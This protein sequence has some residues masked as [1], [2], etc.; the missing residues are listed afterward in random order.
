MWNVPDP[1]S[2]Y[3]WTPEFFID[4]TYVNSNVMWEAWED[5]PYMIGSVVSHNGRFW[6]STKIG[7]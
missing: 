5:S 7:D 1:E 4:Q 2:S 6:R 3:P